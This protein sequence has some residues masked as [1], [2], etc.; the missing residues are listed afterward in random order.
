MCVE[1]ELCNQEISVPSAIT[2]VS[3]EFS[4]TSK[5]SLLPEDVRPF[6]KPGPI[7]ERRQRKNVKSRILTD[8]PIKD[9]IKKE[10][11]T[12][13]AI[14]KKYCKW[15]KNYRNKKQQKN[16]TKKSISFSSEFD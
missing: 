7:C 12:R 1:K 4:R 10:A 15:A 8:S 16:A 11:L 9:C 3:R 13:A 2:P 5:D 14:K 6:P